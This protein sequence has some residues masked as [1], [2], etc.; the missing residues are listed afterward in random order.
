MQTFIF[1]TKHHPVHY[2]VFK[3]KCATWLSGLSS[4]D[5]TGMR[6]RGIWTNRIVSQQSNRNH[7]DWLRQL[8]WLN[9]ILKSI[10]ASAVFHYSVIMS[11]VMFQITGISIVCLTVC[12]GAGQRKYQS[13]AS[14]AFVK[15]IHW[16]PV[17]S[18]HKGPVTLKMLPFDDV[19]MREK[20]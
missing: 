12:W 2:C 17:D 6:E 16:C 15:G 19:I 7:V 18:P 11:A 20:F 5:T 8:T 4:R 3:C 14:L 9:G 10:W 1:L 13:P